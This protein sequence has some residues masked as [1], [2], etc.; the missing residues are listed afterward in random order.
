MTSI[1]QND[2]RRFLKGAAVAGGAA[3]VAP[4]VSTFNTGAA[5]LSGSSTQQLW[6]MNNNE[7]PDCINGRTGTAKRGDITVTRQE[8][9]ARLTIAITLST[10]NDVTTRT[11][12]VLE[13]TGIACFDTNGYCVPDTVVPT[14]CQ[15]WG[16]AAPTDQRTYQYTIQNATASRFVIWFPASGGGGQEEW[17]S[18]PFV[19]P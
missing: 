15:Q 6:K 16:A 9:P 5:A 2:R 7:T 3:W 18:A 10:G 8:G 17:L 1:P 13:S 11:V 14:N 19:L 4:I 12:R